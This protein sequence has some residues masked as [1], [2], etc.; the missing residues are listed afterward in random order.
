MA[1]PPLRKMPP[2]PAFLNTPE[3]NRW[4][5]DLVA[6]IRNDGGI[7]SNQVNGFADVSNTT[8][9][10]SASISSLNTTVNGQ[11]TSITGLSGT[12]S[13]HTSQI[14][15]LQSTVS[16]HTSQIAALQGSGKVLNGSGAPGGGTGNS[17]DLY[18]D[19]I[20]LTSGNPNKIYAKYGGTWYSIV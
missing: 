16:T 13:T 2:P 18:V 9:T 8:Q 7:D 1:T 11:G 12:V 14:S 3:V 17:G 5:H 6:F 4:L 20:A 15:S 10:N 19:N